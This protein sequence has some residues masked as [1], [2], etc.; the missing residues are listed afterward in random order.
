VSAAESFEFLQPIC[1]PGLTEAFPARCML[2]S[3]DALETS[4]LRSF[5]RSMEYSADVSTAEV[6]PFD[7]LE[8]RV[9]YPAAEDAPAGLPVLRE[10]DLDAIAAEPS[11]PD[12]LRHALASPDSGPR[13]VFAIARGLADPS[14]TALRLVPGTGA[15]ELDAAVRGA[16]VSILQGTDPLLPL[17]STTTDLAVT[18]AIAANPRARLLVQPGQRVLAAVA[19]HMQQQP[20]PAEP[21]WS[22]TAEAILQIPGETN[23]RLSFERSSE[24]PDWRLVSIDLTRGSFW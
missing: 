10:A 19:Q 12:W 20:P 16:I 8:S 6:I 5:V 3:R 4:S 22:E 13:L 21:G 1:G 23:R 14:G 18:A 24:Q 2:F 11:T 17:G 15:A 9:I 7:L